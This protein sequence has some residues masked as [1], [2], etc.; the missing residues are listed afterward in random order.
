MKQCLER[1]IAAFDISTE[2]ENAWTKEIEQKSL[3]QKKFLEECTV[4]FVCVLDHA[5]EVLTVLLFLFFSF[6]AWIL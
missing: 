1:G 6:I 2:A 3:L 4:S 5:E